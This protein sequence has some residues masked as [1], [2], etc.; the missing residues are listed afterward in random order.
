MNAAGEDTKAFVLGHKYRREGRLDMGHLT[1]YTLIL[2]R[3]Y[4]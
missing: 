1:T 4:I 2:T 3:I